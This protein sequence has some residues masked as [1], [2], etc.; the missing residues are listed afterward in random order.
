[1]LWD[2]DDDGFVVGDRR[3]SRYRSLCGDKID[4]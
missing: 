3:G 4:D 1:M 2:V